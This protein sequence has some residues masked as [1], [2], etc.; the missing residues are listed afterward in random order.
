MKDTLT[1]LRIPFSFFLMP[2][3]LFA[4]SQS[5]VVDVMDV[6]IMFVALHLFIYPASNAYNSFMDQD[7]SSIGGLKNPPKATRQLFYVSMVMDTIG[8]SLGLLIGLTTLTGL[9]LYVVASRLYSFRGVRLK[10]YPVIGFLT[11]V[12][13]QGG[14][15]FA[16]TQTALGVSY[17]H[18][19]A[20]IAA[21]FLIAGVYPLTQIY[22]HQADEQDGVRTISMLFGYRG[23][24]LFSILMFGVAGLLLFVYFQ[25]IGQ[26]FQFVIFNLFLVPAAV[27]LIY[28]MVKVW[29]DI[30]EATFEHTMRMNLIAS[31]CMNT[32]FMVLTYLNNHG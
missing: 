7:E 16:L 2:V 1:L 28:W 31:G 32:C 12:I 6:F 9:L 3:F 29:R 18:P 23:T 22:Q 19:L 30:R 21:S 11:V 25:S 13:F 14:F 27:Y 15:V 20:A 8:I 26:L 17:H 24:F 10:K 4:L 5:G